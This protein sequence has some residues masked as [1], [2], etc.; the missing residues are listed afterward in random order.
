MAVNMSWEA[1]SVLL[2][3]NAQ[4]SCGEKRRFRPSVLMIVFCLQASSIL[5]SSTTAGGKEEKWHR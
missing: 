4:I 3:E 2:N 1:D 5:D